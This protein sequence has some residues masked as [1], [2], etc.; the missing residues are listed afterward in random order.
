MTPQ[1]LVVARSAAFSTN[2][3]FRA[4]LTEASDATGEALE[5]LLSEISTMNVLLYPGPN[6][7]P[8]A[9]AVYHRLD[10][11]AVEIEYLA[12]AAALRRRG[13]GLALVNKV[14]ELEM[15]MIVARTDDDAIE[16]YR[17]V[18]F[19]CSAS[20]TDPRWPENQRYLCV[21]PFL[22]LV[23]EPLED[24]ASV[25]WVQPVPQPMQIEL[26]PPQESWARD[27]A[28]VKSLIKQTLGARALAVQHLGSTSVPGLP[29]KP[30][31]DIVLT[32][33]DPA[34]EGEY[35]KD[36]VAAGFALRL[37]EPGW[38]SHRLLVSVGQ[39]VL[40]AVNLHVLGPGSPETSRMRSF[41][42]WLRMHDTDRD[43]YARVKYLAAANIN[44]HGGG[45]VM[46]Y[47]AV[48]EPFIQALYARIFAS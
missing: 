10:S 32:V 2:S 11:Y 45:L 34:A 5:T 28:K 14:Q 17:V 1:N 16:F 20:A 12:V 35:V 24:D 15:A 4:L 30:I 41:R 13:V 29:A 3:A 19:Q 18:G 42:D 8:L 37:R 43:E 26:V 6:G 9:L 48:K 38:Y 46:D 21:L 39:G 22:P 40:P 7:D 36:L 33:D 31:I 23:Q 47:N 27:F 25:Q 44:E